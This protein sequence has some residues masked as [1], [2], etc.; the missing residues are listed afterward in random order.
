MFDL[1]AHHSFLRH[2]V[3]DGGRDLSTLADFEIA[4]RR[5]VAEGL[6]F[7]AGI[8]SVRARQL[9]AGVAPEDNLAYLSGLVIGGEIAAAHDAGRLR[10]GSALRIVGSRSLARAYR[11]AFAIAGHDTEALDGADLV[12]AGLSRLARTA[13]LFKGE[14]ER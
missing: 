9:L 12:V 13:N 14:A 10:P 3:K 1:L 2:S 7:L 11:K 6:P 4:V 5:T 8:F